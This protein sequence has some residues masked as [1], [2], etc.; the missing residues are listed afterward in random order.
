MK[1]EYTMSMTSDTA[2]TLLKAVELLM[3]L[4]LNQY[5][6]LTFHLMDF[7]GEGKPEDFWDRRDRA[8]EYLKLAFDEIYKQR[9]QEVNRSDTKWKDDEWYRLYNIMQALRYQIHLAE[10]PDSNGVDS[11]PPCVTGGQPVP[12]CS[13]CKMEV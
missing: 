6:E 8:D 7:V 12:E 2:R 3:R 11:Y 1:V 10:H 9:L 13:F 4:K 5:K